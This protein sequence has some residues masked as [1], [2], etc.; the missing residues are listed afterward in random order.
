[1][2]HRVSL[3]KQVSMSA[4]SM[5]NYHYNSRSENPKED[6]TIEIHQIP[7]IHIL[8]TKDIKDTTELG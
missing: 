3:L 7:E 8:L 5:F 2:L 6:V 4:I 1:M